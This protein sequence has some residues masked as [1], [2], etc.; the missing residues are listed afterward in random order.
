VKLRLRHALAPCALALHTTLAC[1]PAAPPPPPA[2]SASVPRPSA[3]LSPA[4][5]PVASAPAS[6]PVLAPVSST[7]TPAPAPTPTPTLASACHVALIGDSLTDFASN[8][9][10]FVRYLAARCPKSHFENFGK[11]GAMVNQMRKRL[12]ASVLP[13]APVPFTHVLVFGGVNDLYS[14]ETAGRSVPKIEA[15]LSAMYAAA[16]ARGARVVAVTVAPWGGFTRYFTPHRADTTRELNAWILAQR[17]AGTV[18]ATADAFTLL[19][20]GD[21]SRLCERYENAHSDGLHFGK[22]GHEV[23]GQALYEAEFHACP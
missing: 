22:T 1:N 8:G 23:L 13:E 5:T 6:V 11:G 16:K 9:G 14:D 7:P 3:P 4:P 10:G 19:S 2:H 17:A 12:E 21:P 15:D 18:D 20:C